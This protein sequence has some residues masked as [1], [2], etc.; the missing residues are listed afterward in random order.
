MTQS[1][2]RRL[3]AAALAAT[4]LAGCGFHL[5]GA[6]AMPFRTAHV[7]GNQND[8]V[9]TDLRRQLRLNAVEVTDTP[10]DA[11]VVLRVLQL[12]RE[13]DILSL[14][15]SG[16]AR[17]YRLF[18]TLSYAVDTGDGRTLRTPDRITLRRDVTF[19]SSQVLAKAQ[20]EALLYDD[21]K[22]DLVQ[23]LMRRLATV[24]L[25]AAQ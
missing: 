11:Q 25:D 21:M 10:Q 13:R 8:P 5:R 20:E 1:T 22:D 6:I 9:I 23:Q 7:S 12:Q 16:D 18:Y 14:D 17:E 4:T 15:A 2:R 19:N 3:L 24:K